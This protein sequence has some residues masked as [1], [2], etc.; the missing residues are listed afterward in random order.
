MKPSNHVTIIK[1]PVTVESNPNGL[2]AYNSL[3]RGNRIRSLAK[4]VDDNQHMLQRLQTTKSDY[5]TGVWKRNQ[6]EK[7]KALKLMSGKRFC[8]NPYFLH[9]VFS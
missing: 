2:N 7:E 4:I 9:S 5:N 3:N 8:S 1:A 6:E